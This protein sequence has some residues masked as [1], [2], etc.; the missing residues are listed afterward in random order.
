VT[1]VVVVGDLVTDVV[2]SLGGPIA[3]ASD[4]AAAITA[5]PGGSAGNVAAWLADTGTPVALSARVGADVAGEALVADLRAHGVA[6]HVPADPAAAT[7]TIVV[8]VDADGQRTMLTDRGANRC[9]TPDDV[10]A[11]MDAGGSHL[12]LSGY[13]LLDERARPA[14]QAALAM[15]RKAG[16]R[17]SVSP[18]S[19]AP[20]RAVGSEAFMGWT[21]GAWLCV[22]NQAE[23][24]ALAGGSDV[25]G[26][27]RLLATRYG[28]VVVTRGPAGALWCAGGEV[29]AL[30]AAPATPVD[31][32]GAG[33]ALTAGFLSA[34]L[35]GAS[36]PEALNAGL[37]LA[38]R[39]ITRIG[40]RPAPVGAGGQP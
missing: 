16:W 36:P 37:A 22:A 31:T 23:A 17:V 32:T 18:A 15:A 9:L 29:V 26:A 19:E 13:T 3:F 7:G 34:R 24:L 39:A 8:L 1:R 30:P 12:H 27:V 21:A 40:G 28:E 11:A 10:S 25:V 2:V 20:L 5:L 35:A 33:D 4:T 38:A 6:L 14:G